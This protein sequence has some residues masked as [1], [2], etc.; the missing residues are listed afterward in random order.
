VVW[1]EINGKRYKT[2]IDPDGV[3]RFVPDATWVPKIRKMLNLNDVGDVLDGDEYSDFARNIGYSVSGWMELSCNAR[4][5]VKN[6]LW[7]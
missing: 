2:K 1:V 3:Q 4:K 5:R 6:P 7:E